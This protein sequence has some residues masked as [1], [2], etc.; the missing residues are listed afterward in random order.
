MKVNAS[1]RKMSST[2]IMK[3]LHESLHEHATDQIDAAL[4][5]FGIEGTSGQEILETCVECAK[6]VEMKDDGWNGREGQQIFERYDQGKGNF[7]LPGASPELAVEFEVKV[8]GYEEVG[9]GDYWTPTWK[10][11]RIAECKAAKLSLF[12]EAAR[13][14]NSERA[15]Q[16]DGQ[17][18]W[19]G[20]VRWEIDAKLRKENNG[21]RSKENTEI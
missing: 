12:F 15:Y 6:S 20:D 1:P 18:I 9:R 16:L 13:D 14:D 3:L 7:R 10:D 17:T 2:S 8:S 5:K 11:D 21:R 19:E 4:K